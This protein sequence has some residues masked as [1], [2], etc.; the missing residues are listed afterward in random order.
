M[1]AARRAARALMKMDLSLMSDD[2]SSPVP[3][4]TLHRR[5][6]SLILSIVKCEKM[7]HFTHSSPGRDDSLGVGP[8]C[9]RA[10]R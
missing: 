5:P 4:A 3:A 1:A 9:N 6:P 10:E 2:A 8:Y 7:M